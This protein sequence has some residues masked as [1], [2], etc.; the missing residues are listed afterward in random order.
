[1][2]REKMNAIKAKLLE[3]PMNFYKQQ[4]EMEGIRKQT[5]TSFSL[6]TIDT[7]STYK[8]MQVSISDL[9]PFFCL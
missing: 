4:Q 8:L 5:G 1:M 7:S 2:I 3:M 9:C 6:A